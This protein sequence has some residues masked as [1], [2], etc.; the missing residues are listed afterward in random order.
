M[1]SIPARVREELK[2]YVYLYLDPRNGKPFY[3]GK[4]RGN[5]ALSHLTETFKK[6]K[7]KGVGELATLDAEPAIEILRYGMT[8]RE[9]FHVEA[10]A[11]DLFGLE[12][13]TNDVHGKWSK[14]QGRAR[15]DDIV[16]EL[17]AEEVDVEEGVVLININ[18]LYRYGMSD[19]E[20]YDATRS[21]WKVGERRENAAYAM[22]VYR[23][24]V[25]EVYLIA[26]WVPGGATMLSYDHHEEPAEAYRGRWEFVGRVAP[27]RIRRRYLGK[28]VRHYFEKGS[29]NP[30]RY[31]NC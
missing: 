5:R 18:T 1:H 2:F 13:L 21:C 12:D 14:R 29:R 10:A 30:I 19:I 25:R 8:E 7:R 28:S 15:F 17:D 22:S 3:V 26:T 6:A 24:I 20:L 31:V 23:G 27:E 9:A 16:K 11:I 4:G